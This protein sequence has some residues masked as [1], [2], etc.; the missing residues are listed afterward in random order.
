MKAYGLAGSTGA[1]AWYGAGAA[2][3]A[4]AAAISPEAAR[5]Y[6]KGRLGYESPDKK[7]EGR[8]I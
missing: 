7:V 5:T 8:H 4:A 6:R 1:G 3:A 2:G